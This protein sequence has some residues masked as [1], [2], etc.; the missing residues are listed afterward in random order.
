MALFEIF[1]RSK[2]VALFKKR[3]IT[4]RAD[5]SETSSHP[6]LFIWLVSATFLDLQAQ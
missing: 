6:L 3:D 4:Q 1:I 2:L 5:D